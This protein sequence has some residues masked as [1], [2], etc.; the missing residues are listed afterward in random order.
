IEANLVP[1]GTFDELLGDTL[2]LMPDLPRE[3]VSR[4]FES[5]RRIVD[6]SVPGIGGSFPVVRLNALRVFT[7]PKTCRLIECSIGG[8]RDVLQA[9]GDR[10]LVVT[11]SRAGVLAF[12]EDAA[13][14]SAFSDYDI[15]RFDL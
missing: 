9:V 1:I 6:V 2:L 4:V 11:R 5:R 15:T 8:T 14:R 12:G 10:D 3:I 7:W 13:C